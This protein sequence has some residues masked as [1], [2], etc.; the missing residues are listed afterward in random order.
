MKKILLL[1][2]LLGIY[3]N[4]VSQDNIKVMFYNVLNFPNTQPDRISH[5]DVIVDSYAP[6]LFLVCELKSEQGGETILD[7]ALQTPDNKYVMAPWVDNQ[8]TSNNLQQLAFYNSDKLILDN[9][10][11]LQADVL[12][13]DLRDINRYSFKL[14]TPDV[15]TNPIYLEVFVTHLKAGNA[16]S[17]PNNPV[18]RALEVEVLTDYLTA[19][20]ATFSNRYVLFAGD[21]NVYT[22]GEAAYQDIINASGTNGITFVDPINRP[23]AWSNSSSFQDIHTQST[24]RT[25]SHIISEFGNPDGATGGLDD[26]FDFIMMS[27]NLTGNPELEYVTNS[28]DAYGNNGNCFNDNIN[29]SNC[30]GTYSFALRNELFNMS[31]HL[32]VVMELQTNETLSIDELAFDRNLV[33]LTSGNVISNTLSLNIEPRSAESIEMSI[34]NVLGQEVKNISIDGETQLN[35]DVS[36]LS[37]GIYYLKVQADQ[38][39]NTIK[40]LK[41]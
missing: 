36:I 20:A 2:C 13:T 16:S 8:S 28:Y 17:D 25:N 30:T 12:T 34:Y 14:N 41:K 29:D 9:A 37:D 10:A 33:T 35:I 4:G 39:T 23:G 21:F 40:F 1:L 38:Y 7:N 24:L 5:L 22:S 31:D 15:A 27:D 11:T 32:P 19:N 6:D 18:R 26:R 3:T